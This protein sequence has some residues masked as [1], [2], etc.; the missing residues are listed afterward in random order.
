VTALR[1]DG[2]D[3]DVP[4]EDLRQLARDLS[5]LLFSVS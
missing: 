4:E 1:T 2:A 5:A 3:A